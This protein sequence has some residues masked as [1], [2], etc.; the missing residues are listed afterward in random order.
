MVRGLRIKNG[1]LQAAKD[2]DAA[3]DID[4]TKEGDGWQPIYDDN[5]E[6]IAVSPHTPPGLRGIFRRWYCRGVAFR[7]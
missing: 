2:N 6:S 5:G 3:L 1:R 7:A 4:L